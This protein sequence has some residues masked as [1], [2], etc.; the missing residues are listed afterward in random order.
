[1]A[2]VLTFT[3]T[4]PFPEPIF[5]IVPWGVTS[6]TVECWGCG[7]RSGRWGAGSLGFTGGAGGGGYAKGTFAVTPGHQHYLQLAGTMSIGTTV[8]YESI[9][10]IALVRANKGGNS[11]NTLVGGSGGTGVVDA[12]GVD[13]ITRTGGNGADS[14]DST[15]AGGGGGGA[16][17]TA[18]GDPGSSEV[19]GL[20][21]NAD[22]LNAGGTGRK[23]SEGQG[24]GSPVAVAPGG[25]AGGVYRTSLLTSFQCHGAA[26]QMRLTY[27]AATSAGPDQ[28]TTDFR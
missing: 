4:D 22:T 21:G 14:D 12:T 9:E 24:Y 10:G 15:Y 26:G 11:D 18:D 19:G 8:F 6:V 3:T 27:E 5:W 23:Q 13:P 20:G 7:G 1:M 25:G 28:P 16:G 2:V 17:D